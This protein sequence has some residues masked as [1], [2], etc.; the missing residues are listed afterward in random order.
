MWFFEEA[1]FLWFSHCLAPETLYRCHSS[2]HESALCLAYNWLGV[3]QSVWKIGKIEEFT[4]FDLILWGVGFLPKNWTYCRRHY[5]TK[6]LHFTTKLNS[7][8]C[9]SQL[10]LNQ[11][12]RSGHLSLRRAAHRLIEVRL[13]WIHK[14]YW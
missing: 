11:I 9:L 6:V 12:I 1:W 14:W 2:R 4:C 7:L 10:L 8:R 5:F 13:V 3:T